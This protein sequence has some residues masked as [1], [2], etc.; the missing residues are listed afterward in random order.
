MTFPSRAH[1][2]GGQDQG[3]D[4][5]D[6]NLLRGQH[7]PRGNIGGAHPRGT[8]HRRP[9]GNSTLA[10]T[11]HATHEEGHSETDKG[12]RPAKRGC[13]ARQSRDSQGCQTPDQAHADAQS[14][15]RIVAEGQN[16]ERGG[17]QRA[18]H[19]PAGD[20]GARPG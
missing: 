11:D 9:H 1:A 17:Q 16:A 13:P 5:A 18:Q 20:D 2:G 19:R 15:R 4:D 14:E 6:G 3:D 10:S 8:N 12:Q 7:Q